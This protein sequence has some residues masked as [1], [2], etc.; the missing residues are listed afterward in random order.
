MEE[1][2]WRGR[3]CPPVHERDMIWAAN[4]IEELL[5]RGADALK[6]RQDGAE[7]EA[8]YAEGMADGMMMAL[9][10]ITGRRTC[11]SYAP[12]RDNEHTVGCDSARGLCKAILSG[13][14]FESIEV[15]PII[16]SCDGASWRYGQRLRAEEAREIAEYERYERL[17][18]EGLIE[19]DED[20]YEDGE[21]DN[22][23]DE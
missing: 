9:G 12:R 4:R 18:R 7:E 5:D 17:R 20:D 15:Y 8:A 14:A 13:G 21:D 2:K 6:R 1:E 3:D 10:R 23:E 19:D 11:L 16:S 22:G